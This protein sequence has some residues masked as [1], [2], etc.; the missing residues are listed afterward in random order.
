MHVGE[1]FLVLESVCVSFNKSNCLIVLQTLFAT[2]AVMK[3]FPTSL[4][5]FGATVLFNFCLTERCEMISGGFN[6]RFPNHC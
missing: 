1:E 6:W 5:M 2:P 4:S 3:E